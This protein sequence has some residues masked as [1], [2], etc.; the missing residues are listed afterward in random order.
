MVSSKYEA[1]ICSRPDKRREAARTQAKVLA[2]FLDV[3]ATLLAGDTCAVEPRG[4]VLAR[5]LAEDQKD[6]TKVEG[7]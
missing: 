4:V 1:S 2:P 5:V 6:I 7:Y 3:A